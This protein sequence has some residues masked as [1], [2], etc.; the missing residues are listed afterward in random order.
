MLIDIEEIPFL[1]EYLTEQSREDTRRFQLFL[2]RISGKRIIDVCRTLN[3]NKHFDWSQ[4]MDRDKL[5]QELEQEFKI[6]ITNNNPDEPMTYLNMFSH[7]MEARRRN[8]K[9]NIPK[10]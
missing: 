6:T 8:D 9:E 2:S 3:E 4:Y 7:I 1:H 5:I 10:S